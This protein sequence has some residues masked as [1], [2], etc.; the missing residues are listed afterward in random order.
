[1]PSIFS[2][3]Y[4]PRGYRPS[5]AFGFDADTP[6]PSNQYEGF[7]GGMVGSV[8]GFGP[9]GRTPVYGSPTSLPTSVSPV[10]VQQPPM[11]VATQAPGQQPVP[12]FAG[13][14]PEIGRAHV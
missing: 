12:G 8:G 9:T 1:M 7:G 4:A 3:N 11:A 6:N 14:S 13:A 10:R 2:P 5:Q